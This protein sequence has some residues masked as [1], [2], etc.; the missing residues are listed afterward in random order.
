MDIN[1]D[2]LLRLSAKQE[3]LTRTPNVLSMGETI[4]GLIL[5]DP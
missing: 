4:Y 2:H 3:L 1:K 5:F